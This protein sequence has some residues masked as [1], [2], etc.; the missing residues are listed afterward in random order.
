MKMESSHSAAL[1][2][3]YIIFALILMPTQSCAGQSIGGKAY[4]E[5]LPA[6]PL[7]RPLVK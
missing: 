7:H 6:E 4:S 2:C 5:I 3:S 1:T